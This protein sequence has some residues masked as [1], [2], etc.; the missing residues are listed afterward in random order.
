[1]TVMVFTGL[2]ALV[3]LFLML[4]WMRRSTSAG[5]ESTYVDPLAEAEVYLAYG[6]KQQA[7]EILENA[8]LYDDTR[9]DIR[10]KL[11]ELKM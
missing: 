6:R 4:V 9:H 3:A 10:R 5:N 1:M 8:L 2:G 7:I 11:T